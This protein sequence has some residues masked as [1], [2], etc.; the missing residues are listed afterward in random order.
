MSTESNDQ[1]T[2]AVQNKTTK[3]NK[4]SAK[5]K[6]VTNILRKELIK[7][8]IDQDEQILIVLKSFSSNS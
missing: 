3:E 4:K 7:K 1:G 5:Y 6:K 8:V 2:Q